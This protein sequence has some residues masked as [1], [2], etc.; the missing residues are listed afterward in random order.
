V[1]VSKC[2]T[3]SFI[4]AGSHE[5]DAGRLEVASFPLQGIQDAV[6]SRLGGAPDLKTMV[7]EATDTHADH[8]VGWGPV[9]PFPT[10]AVIG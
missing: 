7:R 3:L 4:R 2:G 5:R 1:Q 8:A 10:P 6:D 9:L